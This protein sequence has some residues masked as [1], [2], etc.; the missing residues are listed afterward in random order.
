MRYVYNFGEGRTT[1][2]ASM[3]N[4]LGGKGAG[5]AEM[6]LLGVPVPPGFTVTTEACLEFYDKGRISDE[7]WKEIVQAVNELENFSKKVFGGKENFLLVSVRSGAPISMPGMMDTILN[8]G[9]TKDIIASYKGSDKE[10]FLLDC[11]RRLLSMFGDVVV[12]LDNED[13]EHALSEVK[14]RAGIQTDS[15]LTVENLRE[16]VERFEEIYDK[17]GK[18]FPQDPFEQ[19]KDAVEAVF[20]SWNNKRAVEYRKIHGIPDD[21]G[22]AVNVQEMVFGNLNNR[23]ATGVAFTRD[24]ATGEKELFGEFLVNAQGEDVVAG[25][26]TPSNIKEMRLVFPDSYEKLKK[27][28]AILENRFKD[29]Q[30]M[31]FTIEN[32][33]LFLLQTRNGK[34]TAYAAVK[35]AVDLAEEKIISKKDAIRRIKPEDLVKVLSPTFDLQ[36]KKKAVTEGRLVT[37][38]FAAGPGA[39]SGMVVLSSEKVEKL[40]REGKDVI[41]VRNETSPE[42]IVGM[43]LSKGILTARGGMTSHAAVVARGMGKPCVVGAEE[44][45]IDYNNAVV[46]SK[47]KKIAIKEGDIISIDGTTG[48]VFT[49][50][51]AVK[52][53]SILDETVPIVT[54][55][56]K[57][58]SWADKER[59]IKVRANADTPEDARI[60][61][62]LGAEGIGLCRTE[63]MFFAPDRIRKVQEMIIF[64]GERRRIAIEE[65]KLFQQGD[66]YAVLK[67]MDGLPV[68]I[69]LLDPPLH[70]FLPKGENAIRRLALELG[71]EYKDLSK[72]IEYMSEI[73]PMLGHR[74]C[75]VGITT[76][77][78]YKMQVEAILEAAAKLTR[79]GYSPKVEIM[80][81]LVGIVGEMQKIREEIESLIESFETDSPVLIGTMIEVPRAAI[82]ADQLAKIT[83]FFSFGTNDL[84]QLT[85]GFSRDDAG[86]FL[87]LYI[88]KGILDKDPFS[89]LDKEGVGELIKIATNKGKKSNPEL[90]VGVC[91]EHGGDPESIHFFNTLSIDYVSCSPYRIP[92]ARLAAAHAQIGD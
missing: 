38:G 90:K 54:T 12:G 84:T 49:G 53:V 72:R 37:V 66:F 22:T 69:R 24:P 76:P 18:I 57:L 81:P 61:R 42:D 52:E 78:I 21:L 34:R 19:L 4:L 79:E 15:E 29:M 47:N 51:I 74:G 50:A 8:L 26:R 10:K 2:N 31:E 70:E 1:G 25:I 9:L 14:E 77:E 59:S 62:S 83:D 27:V 5:L 17:N 60:A 40:A 3:K 68:T 39:A 87:P 64:D 56:R 82:I 35:I 67:E 11:Y 36:E 86:K 80:I 71:I 28:A 48:E 45:I 85:L 89:T 30:D 23:S 73:N 65:I 13:F 91:G 63:H 58:L 44:L 88:E 41:L 43:H 46:Y 6:S 92:V 33:K 75:R 16:L 55:V 20:K 32:G 7:I